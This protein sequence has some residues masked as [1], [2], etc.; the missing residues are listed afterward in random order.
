MKRYICDFEPDGSIDGR[1]YRPCPAGSYFAEDRSM[2]F[3]SRRR[4]GSY[5]VARRHYFLSQ[6]CPAWRQ[7]ALVRPWTMQRPLVTVVLF[8]LNPFCSFLEGCGQ[9]RQ[10]AGMRLWQAGCRCCRMGV[11]YA[12]QRPLLSGDG[13]LRLCGCGR[14]VSLAP[15]A[16]VPRITAMQDRVGYSCPG[17]TR[18]GRSSGR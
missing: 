17:E 13:G 7:R 9:V 1:P 5:V 11:H 18:Y 3:S 14:G 4:H 16:P 15:T 8:V 2:V 12:R 10:V 6:D